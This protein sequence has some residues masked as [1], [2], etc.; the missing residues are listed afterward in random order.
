MIIKHKLLQH[1]ISIFVLSIFL[2]L[3]VGS[4]SSNNSSNSPS[5]NSYNKDDDYNQTLKNANI[6]YSNGQYDNA[7]S[8]FERALSL[9]TTSNDDEIINKIAIC[10]KK[11]NEQK[12]KALVKEGDEY[13]NNNQYEQA[14]NIYNQALILIS[15]DTYVVNKL[16]KI[17]E[18]YKDYADLIEKAEKLERESGFSLLLENELDEALECYEKALRLKPN[19]RVPIQKISELTNQIDSRNTRNIV[20][21][22]IAGALLIGVVTFLIVS[23]K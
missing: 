20:I 15:N 23:R 8:Y 21:Y 12:F 22:I 9:K 18:I 19:E 17:K 11:I 16:N 10:N 1:S 3:A 4:D 14:E 2:I 6:Y 7:K 13:F 5:I